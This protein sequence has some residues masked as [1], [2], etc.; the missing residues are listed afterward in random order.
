MNI[1][2]P[3]VK[4]IFENAF[5]QKHNKPFVV[6]GD[7][8]LTYGELKT[9]ILKFSTYF[10]KNGIKAGERVAFSSEDERF[11][12][13]FYLSLVANGIT[14]IF[15][16]P[17]TGGDRANSILNHCEAK[18]IYADKQIQEEWNLKSDKN[19]VVTTIQTGSN[20]TLLQ[21]LL[22]GE[23][24]NTE[25][26]PECV[27]K[28]P[29]TPILEMLDSGADAYILFTSGTTSAPKGVRISYR[30]LF[31]QLANISGVY[32]IDS[33]SRLFNH[34]RLSHSDGMSQGLLVILYNAATL[35]RP[36]SFS[37]QRIE[38][39][40]DTIYRDRITH[41][42]MVPT[43]IGLIYQLKQKD[44]D[45]LD[46]EGFKYV[47]SCG[48]KLESML[49]KQFEDKFKTRI[50]LA[51]GLTETAADCLFAGP[52]DDSHVIGSI[53]KPVG[54]EAKIM[55]EFNQEK[56][57]GEHGEI[58]LKGPL[59]LSGY[60]NAPEINQEVFFGDW[61]KTGDIGYLGEDGCFRITGR[62][63]L[64]I[65]S[66]GINVSPEEVTEVLHTHPSVQDAVTFGLDDE[67]WGEIVV[68]AIVLKKYE[69][70]TK[71]DIAAY[72]RRHLE[73]SKVPSKIYFV[74][75][76]PYGRSGKVIIQEIRKKVLEQQEPALS[77][78]ELRPTFFN[79]VSIC[80]RIPL[81]SVNL[82]MVAEETSEWDSISHLLLIAEAEKH[83]NIEFS[84]LEVMNI[85]ILSDLYHLIEHKTKK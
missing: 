52:G 19:R 26:F 49:W 55:D 23:K 63:K 31:S 50:I 83:F 72:C 81:D 16:D 40:F 20:I 73:E 21:K 62:K 37:I 27:F 3:I 9:S 39:I 85:R 8:T 82:Q 22:S 47:I 57:V 44:Q 68:C 2:N 15:I 65:I 17:E 29:E 14:A 71:G 70:A 78:N 67:T 45:T 59:L 61:F 76:L 51:Y 25:L 35:Y 10:G 66:G 80:F 77:T 69:T 53:G 48:G 12:C 6:F 64:L 34:L 4:N 46:Q 54:C 18:Y 7:S 41:W 36:F 5:R 28:L 79:L 1:S 74:D 56:A 75:E 33:N 13:I 84:P 11:V 60:L 30:S 32:Q 58:W 42:L 38:D 43:M 24:K